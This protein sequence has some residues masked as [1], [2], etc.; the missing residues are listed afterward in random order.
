LQK[1]PDFHQLQH[2]A[3]YQT[4]M[5]QRDGLSSKTLDDRAAEE[6]QLGN[7]DYVIDLL[8]RVKGT[9]P[10]P[11]HAAVVAPVQVAS[12]S[13][14]TPDTPQAPPMTLRELNDAYSMR[15]LSHD[16]YRKKLAE[17]RAANLA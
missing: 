3:A 13:V 15:Q 8:D 10:S 5:S 11:V 17:L 9:V 6:F 12:S 7:V 4:F 2:T 16:E 1:H 14:T